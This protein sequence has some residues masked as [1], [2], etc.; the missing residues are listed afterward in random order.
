MKRF[1]I[2][3]IMPLLLTAAVRWQV[4]QSE[5][6]NLVFP[7]GYGGQASRAIQWL[8]TKRDKVNDLVGY[9]PGKVWIVIEDM[10]MT[11]NGFSNPVGNEIHLYTTPPSGFDLSTRDWMRTVGIHEYAHEVSLSSVWGLPKALGYLF[12]PWVIPNAATP[13]WLIEGVTVYTESHIVGYEGRLESGEYD[14]NV[15]T[16]ASEG[17]ITRNWNME[18]SL[19]EYPLG[20]IYAYGGPFYEWLVETKGEEAIGTFYRKHGSRIPIF[21]LDRSA[22]DAFDQ[23]FPSL[24]DDWQESV[25]ERA[26]DFIPADSA[27]Q[28]ITKKGWYFS[29]G[30]ATDGEKIYYCRVY[31]KKLA[32]LYGKF[33]IDIVAYDPQA[34][35]AGVA[36]VTGVTGVEEVLK[37]PLTSITSPIRVH[38]GVLY[39]G[40]SVNRLGFPNTSG[41]SF[42]ELVQIRALD[43]KDRHEAVI[44]EGRVR[45]F[46]RLPDE[47]FLLSLDPENARF[48]SILE[49]IPPEGGET[50]RIWEGDTLIGEILAS[51]DGKIYMSARTQGE[52]WDIWE[53]S[54]KDAWR[55]LTNSVWSETGLS[56]DMGGKIMYSANPYGTDGAV[57]S[58]VLDPKSGAIE[59]FKTPSYTQNPVL[60]GDR[61]YF[62]SL[63]PR[64]NDLYSVK[65]ALTEAVFPST[66][67]EQV[68]TL[69]PAWDGDFK[70]RSP[71][72]PYLTLLRPWVRVPYFTMEWS[73]A[74]GLTHLAPGLY[75]QG[76]DV[77]GENS[78]SIR[79]DYDVVGLAPSASVFWSNYRF[80]PLG[81]FLDAGFGPLWNINDSL[82]GYSFSINPS[83]S[84]PLVARSRRGLRSIYWGEGF[85][86]YGPL[87]DYRSL[88][89]SISAS[90]AWPFWSLAA[91]AS[92]GWES[93]IF[94]TRERSILALRGAAAVDLLGGV[95]IGDISS[96]LDLS[97]Q[98]Q[99]AYYYYNPIRGY[100][101]TL[102]TTDWTFQTATL[103]YR[104]RLLKMR[105]GIWNPNIFFEDLYVSVFA[106]AAFDS[107]EVLGASAG[108]LMGP[109]IHAAW[110]FLTINPMFGVAIT[111]DGDIQPVYSINASIPIDLGRKRKD[112]LDF[113]KKPWEKDPLSY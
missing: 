43:L 103:E 84:I 51:D 41:L 70:E 87:L 108:I 73:S 14:A 11:V 76:A 59:Q 89:S 49:R 21:S 81:L 80:G 29:G 38:D 8:E 74:Q 88:E 57:G 69:E 102:T 16:R 39:Y 22:R 75:F 10:G 7:K 32:P 19:Y 101:T 15:L 62:M 40:A 97:A 64:G 4:L 23:R 63:N 77:L 18:G 48:G 110:D 30:M 53:Y 31:G 1:G 107:H 82:A 35:V 71:L 58:Y 94:S 100:Y 99:T 12:G 6:Y 45:A 91:R 79:A 98:K 112:G 42:G 113:I 52:N 92:H 46:D 56:L 24:L 67:T 104:R 86:A 47:S 37:R 20:A 93:P 44:F 105:F 66:Y 96:R 78:Y 27:A 28:R 61:L 2:L 9:D 83:M 55:R 111:R 26:A 5:H 25:K 3:S 65:P 17:K 68:S 36:G 95:I 60:L 109:E 33:Y 85:N 90:F 50:E 13:G 34:G 106:D 54:D 72:S